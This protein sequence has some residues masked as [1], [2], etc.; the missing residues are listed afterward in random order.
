MVGN[1]QAG[2]SLLTITGNRSE[3]GGCATVQWDDEGVVPDEFTLVEDGVL[4]DF[5]TTREG[6]GW[7][8]T[9]Y[10]KAGKP[11]RSHACASALSA[12]DAPLQ[13]TPNLM[14]A[15]GSEA[16]DFDALVA[17]MSTGIAIKGMQPD[18]DFQGMTGL[19]VGRVYEVKRGKR[20]ALLNAAGILFRA[21]ELWKALFAVGGK[22]SLQRY[23]MQTS[24]G[25]PAQYAYHSVTAVPALFRQ[26]TLIDVLRKA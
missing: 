13:R 5:Q 22:T 18:M 1:Y 19:G 26:L 24:K 12:A 21:P 7:L 16:L 9:S 17:G 8:K 14:L 23:G 10:A 6:A 20:V 25:E 15:P 11:F 2:S 3:P 4:T